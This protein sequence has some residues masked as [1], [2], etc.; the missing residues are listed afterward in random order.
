MN[1]IYKYYSLYLALAVSKV[2]NTKKHTAIRKP[3]EL[4]RSRSFKVNLSRSCAAG[5]NRVAKM[6]KIGDFHQNNQNEGNP[7]QG[8]GDSLRHSW[9]LTSQKYDNCIKVGWDG[10]DGRDGKNNNCKKDDWNDH[11]VN[12]QRYDNLIKDGWDDKDNR[13]SEDDRWQKW[14]NFGVDKDSKGGKP[15][16]II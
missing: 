9:I 14:Q 2:Q 13:N 1:T 4:R 7:Y 8:I 16:H 15:G 3:L 12:C 6:F 10:R 5:I 11:D